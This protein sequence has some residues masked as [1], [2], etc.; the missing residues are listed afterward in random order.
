[1]KELRDKL[2]SYN[3]FN[4][5][6]PGTIFVAAAQRIS[7]HRFE[8]ENIV[9]ELFLY[10]FIG[11]VISRMGSLTVEP[12]MKK[13]KFVKFVTYKEFVSACEKDA[14]IEVLSEQN[15]TYR[16]LSTSGFLG[17]THFPKAL[18][19]GFVQARSKTIEEFRLLMSPAEITTG[20]TARR[21]ARLGRLHCQYDSDSDVSSLPPRRDTPRL[22]RYSLPIRAADL[23]FVLANSRLP[24]EG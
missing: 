1:M 17:K 24:Q 10:Y 3:L 16:T 13:L 7:A 12:S 23:R 4:Y 6:L 18:F 2:S 20:E 9:V 14:K 21:Q 19:D 5:L 15:N 11:L 8:N 22:P